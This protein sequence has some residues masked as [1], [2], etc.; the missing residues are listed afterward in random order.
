M[1]CLLKCMWAVCFLAIDLPGF[2]QV[3]ESKLPTPASIQVIVSDQNG[4]PIPGAEVVWSDEM[5][6]YR[7][8]G[9]S[10]SRLDWPKTDLDGRCSI[11]L[12]REGAFR[13]VVRRDGYLDAGDLG[14]LEHVEVVQV[15]FGKS[16]KLFVDLVR[17]AS[18]RGTVYLEDGRRVAGADVRLQ[19]AALTWTGTIRGAVPKWLMATTDDQGNF[20]FPVVPPAQYGMWIAPPA[21]IVSDSL[22]KNDRGEWTGYGTV[23]WHTSV[24]ELRRI[25]PVDVAPGEDV[26]GYNVV[27][28]KTRVY[29]IQ[30][31]LREWT[32]KPLLHAKVSVRAEAEEPVTLLEP[33]PVNALTGDFDFPALPEGH[34]AL[35]VYRDDASEAPPY[36]IP[37]ES[38][39]GIPSDPAL[40]PSLKSRHA[41]RIPPW[42]QVEGE[43]TIMRP[44]STV[45]QDPKAPLEEPQ[46]QPIR[47]NPHV[48]PAP[49]LVSLT[50]VG[51]HFA[52]RTDSVL[53]ESAETSNW[54]S[55]KFPAQDLPPGSY[56]FR[57]QAPEPWY[58]VSAR[59][60]NK[61]LWE[62]PIF[63][64][65]PS[66]RP[67]PTQFV[68]EIRQGGSAM[69]GQVVNDQSQPVA[70]GAMC[71]YAEEPAR[72]QQPGGAFCVRADGGGEFRS[73]WM[74]PGK[75]MI[76]AFKK[77]PHENPASP[78]F[79][80]KYERHA[81]VV[82]V[83]EKGE[84]GRRSIVVVD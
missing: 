14:Q 29:P 16:V 70:N 17:S 20:A 59:G 28:R 66:Q 19:P 36:A 6:G 63:P 78:A 37:F 65:A 54:I 2:A 9:R 73:R 69:G 75:W 49:V 79:K 39:G 81:Q 43:V 72:R 84:L 58:V 38:G 40:G 21:R 61:D 25:I 48:Q 68:V 46:P 50:P 47:R 13:V 35:L 15:D 60:E 5:T 82:T 1:T 80:E 30:G 27:L 77:K 45:V 51:L 76:W 4:Q 22:E 83:P 12:P 31:T 8:A 42:R 24:E 33:R 52:V 57:V 32:L 71:A 7:Q 10:T 26:R 64:V 23:V 55:M 18:F 53:L 56:E 11:D 62:S 44:D 67:S 34:Y 74:S 3:G 41:V